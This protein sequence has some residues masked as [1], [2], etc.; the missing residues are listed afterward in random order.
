MLNHWLS[1]LKHLDMKLLLKKINRRTRSFGFDIWKFI[2]AMRGVPFYFK[3][4]KELKK[5]KGDDQTFVVRK[6]FPILN[7][8]FESGG[9]ASG[10]YFHQDLYV[11]RK[12]YKNNPVKH[13]D[14][15]SRVDGFVAHVA[16]FRKIEI[17]DIRNIENKVDNLVFKQQDMMQLSDELIGYC[18]S[19]SSLHAIEHFGLGRYGDPIDYL[20]YEKAL[21]NITA[22]LKTGGKFYF[23][24]P[25][26]QQR[27]E[28]NAQ[29]VFSVQFLLD[30]FKKDYEIVAF[31]YVDDEGDFH[32]NVTLSESKAEDSFGCTFG[33]GIFEL[34]KK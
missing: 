21:N 5:Q 18:D 16:V 19:I 20:G 2:N 9:T 11:A 33:C 32:Q 1:P 27:I 15:G 6:N 31:S 28:F 22:I 25:I 17:F 4:Y 24:V 7:E 3:D 29:R 34:T 14:I 30:F 8:R 23:S 26:G 10:H 12:V 13:V